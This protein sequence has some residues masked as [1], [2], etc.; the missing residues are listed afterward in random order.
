M[1]RGEPNA[2]LVD[3]A[4]QREPDGAGKRALVVGCGLGQD[5]EYLAGL[6]FR[7]TAFGI[8]PTAVNGARERFPKSAVDFV[9]ANLLDP[10]A[11]WA[12]AFDLV[13]ESITIQSMPLSVRADAI[14]N[15]GPHGGTRRAAA[16]H[17]RHETRPTR[18]TPGSS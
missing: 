9:V 14:V 1:G 3:W 8:A 7:T 17:L 18:G 10:P 4:E 15:V 12:C 13:V 11:E 6:G 5:A 16:G 2:L